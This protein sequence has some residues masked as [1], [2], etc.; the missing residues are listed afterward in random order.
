MVPHRINRP[1]IWLAIIGIVLYFGVILINLLPGVNGV[2][3]ELSGPKVT[4]EQAADLARQF[5]HT[6]Q[7]DYTPNKINIIYQSDKGLSGYLQKAK[8]TEEYSTRYGDNYPL[9]Y[10]EVQMFDS[11]NRLNWIIFVGLNEPKVTAWN[12][13][14]AAPAS[15]GSQESRR[16]LAE[17]FLAENGYDPADL[18]LMQGSRS[19]LLMYESAKESIGESRLQL[20]VAVRGEEVV[21]FVPS[22]SVPESFRQWLAGQERSAGLMSY[23]GLGGMFLLSIAALILVIINRKKVRFSRGI[24]FA[25]IFAGLYGLHTINSWPGASTQIPPEDAAIFNVVYIV[26]TF[27]IIALLAG[28]QYFAAISGDQLWRAQGW[29]PWPRW[30]DSNFGEDMFY[31]M[32]R[33]YLL[34]LFILGVQQV[35][36]FIA[37]EAFDSFAVN[38]PTQS[39]LNMYWPA[40]FPLLAW[41]AG[42]SEEIMYRLFG[43]ALFQKWFR[44]RFLAVL[45]P[46]IIWALGHTGYTIYPSYTRLFE[47]A[48]LGIIFGY[49]FLKYGL[50]TAIFT[51]VTMDI[52]LMALS[53]MTTTPSTSNILIG[54]GYILMPAITG[55]IL[56]WIHSLFR[57]RSGPASTV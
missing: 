30:R 32:G 44:L 51:H 1:L 26:F 48:V 17:S 12:Q 54:V 39:V 15:S 33:G 16:L 34:C 43:I 35:L 46:S 55:Y 20:G 40:L 49:I 24:L 56:M 45:V 13:K 53:L 41:M 5:V 19:S 4:E 42:T 52:I 25:L 57:K 8:L 21:G 10:W 47:V 28:A 18:Q 50:M 2:E 37:G 11:R 14:Q 38:D 23:I 27:L 7:P 9:D 22:F 6:K 29:N 31:G 3:E 36:F